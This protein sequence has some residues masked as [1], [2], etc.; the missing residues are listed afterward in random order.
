MRSNRRFIYRERSQ[1]RR[2]LFFIRP[3]TPSDLLGA[4]TISAPELSCGCL[5]ELTWN[6][7]KPLSLNGDDPREMVTVLGLALALA[8]RILPSP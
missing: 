7:Q 4:G 6:G 3:Y 8:G 1:K 5:L 2:R